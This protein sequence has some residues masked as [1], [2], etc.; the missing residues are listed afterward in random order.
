MN[1]KLIGLAVSGNKV[2]DVQAAIENAEKA[3]VEAVWMTTGGARLDSV[4]TFAAAASWTQSIKFGTSI[5][6]TFRATHW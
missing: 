2:S 1:G 5:V 3:G 6:P 4:T